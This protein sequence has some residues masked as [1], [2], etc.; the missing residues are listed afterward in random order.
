MVLWNY[1]R[2]HYEQMKSNVILTEKRLALL[3]NIACEELIPM[4]RWIQVEKKAG[5]QENVMWVI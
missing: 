4:K 2:E 5:Y 1:D 3:N